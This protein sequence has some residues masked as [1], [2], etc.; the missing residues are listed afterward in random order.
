M[1]RDE[2]GDTAKCNSAVVDK[3]TE[4]TI[5]RIHALLF[6]VVRKDAAAPSMALG[7]ASCPISL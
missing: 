3:E 6:E 2:G 7:T 5:Q 4:A 1:S